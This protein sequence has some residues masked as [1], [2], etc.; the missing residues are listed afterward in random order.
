MSSGAVE[1]PL[2]VALLGGGTVGAQVARLLV[3][4]AHD[5]EA[6][7]ETYSEEIQVFTYPDVPLGNKG[8]AHLGS[9]FEPMFAEGKVSV[10]IV[11]QIVQGKHVVNHEIVSYDG[12]DE[13][14]VSIYE[15]EDGLIKTVRFVRE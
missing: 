11:H 10:R 15:V 13:T 9:I 8:K 14:Y 4:N 6:F 1:R 7:L 5:L 3:D 12:K 2:T